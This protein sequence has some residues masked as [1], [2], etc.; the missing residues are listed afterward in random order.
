MSACIS[1]GQKRNSEV[2]RA[3]ENGQ[4]T[5]KRKVEEI[6]RDKDGFEKVERKK[7]W[8]IWKKPASK[9]AGGATPG[10]SN[11]RIREVLDDDTQERTPDRFGPNEQKPPVKS[12]RSPD[13]QPRLGKHLF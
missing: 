12:D 6:K 8:N 1:G 3:N 4:Q 10:P 13:E 5:Q 7:G 9:T 11:P 2:V